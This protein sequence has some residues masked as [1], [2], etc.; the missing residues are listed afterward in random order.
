MTSEIRT[1]IVSNE[2]P[3]FEAGKKLLQA[4]MDYWEEYRKVS[5][6][7]AVVWLGDE[8]GR[9]VVLTR[10]EYRRQIMENIEPLDGEKFFGHGA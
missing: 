3:L 8:A 9:L 6:G 5:G 10:S 1:N 4:A 7:S 2:G